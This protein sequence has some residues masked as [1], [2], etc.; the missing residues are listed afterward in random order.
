M[1]EG[2][3][4]LSG[5]KQG[6]VGLELTGQDDKVKKLE[7][8]LRKKEGEI[9]A[10]DGTIK[11]IN[12][13]LQQTQKKLNEEE[14]QH[15]MMRKMVEKEREEK[16]ETFEMEKQKLNKKIRDLEGRLGKPHSASVPTDTPQQWAEER[17][18]ML[19]QIRAY[20]RESDAIKSALAQEKEKVS[21]LILDSV[22]LLL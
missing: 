10:K 17:S 14:A 9:L 1:K 19:V 16:C 21:L 5:D 3:Q 15:T 18:Q 7:L 2:T 20:K 6:A 8:L 22:L 4:P 13:E 12:K 11:R